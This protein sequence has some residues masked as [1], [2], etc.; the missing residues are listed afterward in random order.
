MARQR[1]LVDTRPGLHRTSP[2]VFTGLG[3]DLADRGKVEAAIVYY[4]KALEIDP[5][6]S[7][8]HNNLGL[9]LR[10]GAES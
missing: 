4:R 10:P 5:R 1:D 9:A 2:L 3:K 6:F 8:A 7:E